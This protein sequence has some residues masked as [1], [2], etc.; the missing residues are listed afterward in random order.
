[1]SFICSRAMFKQASTLQLDPCGTNTTENPN[2]K[3]TEQTNEQTTP[4]TVTTLTVCYNV[5]VTTKTTASIA[6]TLPAASSNNV[7][8]TTNDTSPHV[9]TTSHRDAK[10]DGTGT[11][12]LGESDSKGNDTGKVT[13]RSK[14]PKPEL[15]PWCSLTTFV[16]TPHKTAAGKTGKFGRR[17]T[18]TV[19]PSLSGSCPPCPK[20]CCSN[21]VQ[22]A[23][24]GPFRTADSNVTEGGTASPFQK[25]PG[26]TASSDG[27]STICPSCSKPVPPVHTLRRTKAT[28]SIRS[29]ERSDTTR[30]S[31]AN[32]RRAS[33]VVEVD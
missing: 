1:M 10:P 32:T 20:K 22:V 29:R 2:R 15:P 26:S 17:S 27:D 28:R 23:K 7:N 4:F 30:T 11:Q 8:S 9:S 18:T 13:D 12:C 25:S 24:A 21:D 3:I 33:A 14:V 31:R 19:S 5:T 16:S 6:T